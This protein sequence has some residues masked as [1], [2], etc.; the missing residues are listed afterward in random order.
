MYSVTVTDNN[1]YGTSLTGITASVI[2]KSIPPATINVP[3]AG[4][5]CASFPNLSISDATSG[6][7]WSSSDNTIATVGSTSP[8]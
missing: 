4:L 6:G 1:G 5:L 7:A 2:V 3:G 8:T